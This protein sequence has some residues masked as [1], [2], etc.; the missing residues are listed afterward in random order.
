MTGY[1]SRREP[2][3]VHRCRTA[4]SHASETSDYNEGQ[5][6]TTTIVFINKN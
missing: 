6:P 5:S 4:A 1:S 3:C 2:S